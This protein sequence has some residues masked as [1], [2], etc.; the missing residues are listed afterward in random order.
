[1]V[2]SGNPAK[3]IGAL[4]IKLQSHV[5]STELIKLRER[6][7][8]VRA[9]H[10]RS[11]LD[12]ITERQHLSVACLFSGQLFISDR[13]AKG[14]IG[15]FPTQNFIVAFMDQ[16]KFQ[17]GGSFNG[18]ANLFAVFLLQAR[19]L[20]KDAVFSN[21]LDNWLGDAIAVN[22]LANNLHSL[23][24]GRLLVFGVDFRQIHFNQKREASLEIKP[25]L[26]A[27]I[28]VGINTGQ[29]QANDQH[30]FPKCFLAHD[31]LPEDEVGNLN[32][33]RL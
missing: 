32:L 12:V 9:R 2:G 23:L 4:P 10:F 27:V 7:L 28:E 19:D 30:D 29:H 8:E 31:W 26:D 11:F 13:R 33:C 16:P 14:W 5:R 3:Q 22:A 17:K 24:H 20:N 6:A 1:M 15:H 25:Q 18:I 21:G